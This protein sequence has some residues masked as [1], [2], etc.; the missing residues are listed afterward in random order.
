MKPY[1][2]LG[3]YSPPAAA[4]PARIDVLRCMVVREGRCDAPSRCVIHASVA[5]QIFRSHLA[6]ADREHFLALLLDTRNHIL[7]INTI[8]IGT[9]DECLVHPREV[10]KPALIMGAASVIVGHNHPSGDPEPSPTDLATTL[11]LRQAGELLRVPLLDHV[12]VGSGKS[13]VSLKERGLLL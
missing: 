1:S 13:Y 5:A 7:G 2:V 6:G 12:I 9:L 10:F 8:G 3:E 4:R 11:R